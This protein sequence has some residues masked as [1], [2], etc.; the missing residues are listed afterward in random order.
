MKILLILFLGIN[1]LHSQTVLMDSTSKL[2]KFT[3][4]FSGS[5]TNL[6]GGSTSSYYRDVEY[7]TQ[8]TFFVG[9][10]TPGVMAVSNQ[11]SNVSVSPMFTLSTFYRP[12]KDWYFGSVRVSRFTVSR[13]TYF[14][15]MTPTGNIDASIKTN[16]IVYPMSIG[17]G[18]SN[19]QLS[20]V[21]AELGVIYALAQIRE[22]SSLTGY[23]SV[24]ASSNGQGFG[25]YFILSPRLEIVNS[26]IL[27]LEVSSRWL[28]IWYYR[29]NN[30]F[31]GMNSFS[32]DG[33]IYSIGL[34]TAF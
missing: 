25:L 6:R 24:M 12:H 34:E 8:P 33:F 31:I 1:S 19:P 11:H 23:P 17:G 16:H 27:N 18:I 13:E 4:M 20:G 3:F 10:I 2:P 28:N 32:Y 5:M 7:L 14:P 30:N 15:F 22:E 21:R 29:D 9:A 26:V